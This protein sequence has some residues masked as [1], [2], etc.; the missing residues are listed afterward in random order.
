[1]I[2]A[3]VVTALILIVLTAIIYIP[4]KM[5]KDK[6]I[7]ENFKKNNNIIDEKTPINS[8]DSSRTT[9]NSSVIAKLDSLVKQLEKSK[10]WNTDEI[11]KELK[12]IKKEQKRTKDPEILSRIDFIEA[13]IEKIDKK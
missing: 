6:A 13:L 4:I 8:N 3:T 12:K 7:I 5:K 2:I 10:T 11:H 1:M 9:K